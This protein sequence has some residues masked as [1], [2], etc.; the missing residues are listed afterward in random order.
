MT[1]KP[2][3]GPLNGQGLAAYLL[4]VNLIG[5]LVRKGLISS[6]E[7]DQVVINSLEVL[8]VYPPNTDVI[9]RARKQL[10]ELLKIIAPKDD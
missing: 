4:L 6:A 8:E 3:E 1:E 7:M 9:V 5:L 2:I 10:G